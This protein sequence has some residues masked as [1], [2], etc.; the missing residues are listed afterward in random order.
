MNALTKCAALLAAAT[1]SAAASLS[2]M[3]ADFQIGV[4]Q[5]LTGPNSKFGSQTYKG[6][7]LAAEK[8]NGSGGIKGNTLK[9]L[10]EDT[11]GNKDQ[12]VNA[13][14]KLI[15]SDKVPL[16][17]GPTL[18]IEAFA[19]APVAQER[20]V[21]MVT[22]NPTAKGIP[23]QGS[24][25]FRTSLAESMLIP[26]SVA[27]AKA[28]FGFKRVAIF[29][30]NDDTNMKASFDVFK[31][32][33]AKEG[34]EVLAVETFATKDTDFSAQLTKL[35]GLN[36]E[37]ILTGAYPDT[38]ASIMSQARRLG[39]PRSLVFIGGNGF[40]SPKLMELAGESAEGA[41]VSSP[42]YLEKADPVNADFVRRYRAKFNEDPDTFAAQGY[43]GLLL[44]ATALNKAAN[45]ERKTIRDALAN[46][47]HPGLFGNFRFAGNRDP[48]N[49]DG[50]VTLTV[51]NGKFQPL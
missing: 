17:L 3:A 40:N 24:Y 10:V 35:K 51:R 15:G 2:A 43:D 42:W 33:A 9:L 37:A 44:I 4:V 18:S 6:I 48:A 28:K 45:L 39:L 36:V 20:E 47:E 19:A 21:S 25:I 38:A 8:I 23:D 34:L 46:V 32:V 30:A 50:A 14:R 27:R 1:L 7:Q 13:F 22:V 29:Y 12:A 16:I 31:E 41:I 11:A 26:Q 5:V 49:A